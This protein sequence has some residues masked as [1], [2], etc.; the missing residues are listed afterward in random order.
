MIKIRD[1]MVKEVITSIGEITIKEAVKILYE[2][3]IGSIVIVDHDNRPKGIFT[4]RDAIRCIAMGKPLDTRLENE[5]TKKII[6]V[7][8]NIGFRELKALYSSKGIR[9]FPVVDEHNH[10]E[11]ILNIRTIFDEIL[12]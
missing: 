9:H 3:H 12:G 6:T 5:M 8:D 2:K 7:K 1:I 10:L 4:E 11:G